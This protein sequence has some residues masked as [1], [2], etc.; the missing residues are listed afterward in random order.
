M[1]PLDLSRTRQ[2]AQISTNRVF[3][4]LVSTAKVRGEDSAL[5]AKQLQDVLVALFLSV[6]FGLRPLLVS[7]CPAARVYLYMHVY[8]RI[9][10]FMH[11][12]A[13]G[14]AIQGVSQ[15]HSVLAVVFDYGNVLCLEQ[16]LEDMK[17]MAL[18]CGIPHERFS[19]LYWKLR[20]RP[21]ISMDLPT[22]QRLLASKNWV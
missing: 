12:T 6:R 7:L 19:G 21:G 15:K 9:I 20:P 18:V 8:T 1:Y 11:N 5:T 14:S 16:T 13:K 3:R 22:G 4:D 2:F 10:L 17:G